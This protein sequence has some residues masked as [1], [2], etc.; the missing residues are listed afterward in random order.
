MK[1]IRYGVT[2]SKL[3][4]N[5]LETVRYWRNHPQVS[6]YMEYRQFITSEMQ[7]N[8]FASINNNSNFFFV[9]EHNKTEVGLI[10]TANINYQSKTG[11]CGIFVWDAAYAGSP[12]PV[13]AALSMLDFVFLILDLDFTGIKVHKDNKKALAY[14]LSLGYELMPDSEGSVFRQYRL[15]RENYFAKAALLRNLGKKMF[16]NVSYL[17]LNPNEAIP[18]NTGKLSEQALAQLNITLATHLT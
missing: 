13:F 3:T 16:G 11:N 12:V 9:I 5:H 1:W 15:H 14:N 8:W 7:K 6:K 18:N 4:E 17:F 10:N 2:L